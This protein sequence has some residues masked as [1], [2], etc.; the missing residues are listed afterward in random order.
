MSLSNLSAFCIFPLILSLPIMK[1][2]AGLILPLN[3]SKK[4]LLSI[5]RV[6][7]GADGGSP[8]PH[9]PEPFF[10]STNLKKKLI[11]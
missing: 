2:V 7:S 1:A 10:R 9:D 8:R 3:M 6:A 11:I 4:F 5:V